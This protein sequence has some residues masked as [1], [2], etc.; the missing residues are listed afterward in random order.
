MAKIR[1]QDAD[2]GIQ[3]HEIS[4]DESAACFG[5]FEDD[6]D[7]VEWIECTNENCRVWAHAECLQM[8][9]VCIAYETS[10]NC[11]FN[12]GQRSSYIL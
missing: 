11:L 9:P 7:S 6:D 2:A 8:W 10:L 4:K 1:S 3:H 5:L 12:H